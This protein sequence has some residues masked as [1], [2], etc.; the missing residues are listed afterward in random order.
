[1]NTVTKKQVGKERVYS[2][3][4]S[5]SWFI[6]AGSQGRNS[7]RAGGTSR[8]ELTQKPWRGAAYWLAFPQLLSLLSCSTQDHQSRDGT[9]HNGPSHP[10]PLIEKMPYSWISWR[11]FL[12]WGSLLCDDSSLSQFDTQNQSVQGGGKDG[13]RTVL[14]FWWGLHWI[15]TLLLVGWAFLQC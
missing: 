10:W 7:S 3:Y 14:E 9:T 5:R 1:M 15:C 8:Q 2:A 13:Y 6:T 4:I 11:H 12:N